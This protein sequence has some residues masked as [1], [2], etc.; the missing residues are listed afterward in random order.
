MAKVKKGKE[1]PLYTRSGTEVTDELAEAWA[2]EAER[3]YDLSELTRQYVG[4]PSLGKRGVSPRISFVPQRTSSPVPS[5]GPTP[6]SG[7][8]AT[9]LARR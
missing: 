9:S 7:R 3:G 4:R 2:D 1:E 6:R 5:A 8:S